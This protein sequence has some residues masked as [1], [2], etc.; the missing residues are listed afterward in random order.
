[1][2]KA[3]KN[4]NSVSAAMVK[5]DRFVGSAAV[6]ILAMGSCPGWGG[7]DPRRHPEPLLQPAPHMK[8]KVNIEP[9][10]LPNAL[11]V[12]E[13][14]AVKVEAI[15]ENGTRCYSCSVAWNS[16]RLG[17]AR[18][19]GIGESGGTHTGT[20]EPIAPGSVTLTITSVQAV[21]LP[22]SARASIGA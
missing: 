10:Q 13:R 6:F 20:L 19:T 14:V 18:W 16:D 15:L 1:M 2:L 22:V 5:A 12:G 4:P 3:A 8:L 7:H 21:A 17:I 11:R 9:A